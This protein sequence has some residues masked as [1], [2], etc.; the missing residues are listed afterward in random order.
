MFIKRSPKRAPSAHDPAWYTSSDRLFG[1]VKKPLLWLNAGVLVL[2]VLSCA[3]FAARVRRYT[4]P[5]TFHYITDEQLRSTM[6]RLAY[7]SRELRQ[8][9]TS[10]EETVAHRADV[11][12][13]L[14]MME[15]TTIELNRTGWPT[16]HP[17]IDA[18]RSSLLQD[19]RAAQNA[20]SHDPPNF[21][22]AGTVSGAC[23]YCH[24]SR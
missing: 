23:A 7:H 18:N 17:L 16:N 9:M 11:L 20:V 19:I 5:P 13:H 4:Y 22:L 24:P 21:L 2:Q 3:D 14:Q 15:Q 6:W 1:A 12:G 10:P 8:L